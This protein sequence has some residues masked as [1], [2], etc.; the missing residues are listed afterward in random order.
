MHHIDSAVSKSFGGDRHPGTWPESVSL[1]IQTHPYGNIYVKL[2]LCNDID[3][4]MFVCDIMKGWGWV[5]SVW[6]VS[7]NNL[8]I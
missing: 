6:S 1:K 2:Q 3:N 5:K 8:Q 7:S 4:E